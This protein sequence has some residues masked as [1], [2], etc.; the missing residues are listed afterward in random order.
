MA[1][2]E[3]PITSRLDRLDNISRHLEEIRGPSRSSKSSGASII[4]SETPTSNSQASS[5]DLSPRSLERHSR[6]ID[7]VIVETEVK[8]T[9][10]ERLEQVE[11]RVL[12]LC[13]QLDEQIEAERRMK[14]KSEKKS[15][16]KGLK[17]LVQK[18]MKG[19]GTHKARNDHHQHVL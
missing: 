6:P 16:K 18:C 11:D 5:V 12:K 13:L 2:V 4:S 15:H 9:I 8:G 1:I 7:H 17:Q 3:E 19:E 10:I 14:E